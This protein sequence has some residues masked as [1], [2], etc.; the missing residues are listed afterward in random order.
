MIEGEIIYEKETRDPQQDLEE[1]SSKKHSTASRNESLPPLS[2]PSRKRSSV[3]QPVEQLPVPLPLEEMGNEDSKHSIDAVITGP[4]VEELK[5]TDEMLQ[6]AHT[7]RQ[8]LQGGERTTVTRKLL[9]RKKVLQPHEE[10]QRT[11]GRNIAVLKPIPQGTNIKEVVNLGAPP[12]GPRVDESGTFVPHSLLGEVD[13]YAAELQNTVSE[14]TFNRTIT[15]LSAVPPVYR[16]PTSAEK[17]PKLSFHEKHSIPYESNALDRWKT[18]MMDRKRQ[19]EQLAN[20]I[21][22]SPHKLTM[23][24]GDGFR[25]IQ[26]QRTLVDRAIPLLEHGKGYRV[27]SEFFSQGVQLGDTETGIRTAVTMTEQGHPPEL[28]L[29]G[30]PDYIRREKGVSLGLEKNVPSHYTWK[31]SLYLAQR[32]T[33]LKMVSRELDPHYPDFSSLE[34]VGRSTA[35]PREG[36][37]CTALPRVSSLDSLELSSDSES[38]PEQNILELDHMEPLASQTDLSVPM[39]GPA[40]CVNDDVL[41]WEGP[42]RFSAASPKEFFVSFTSEPKEIVRSSLLLINCGTTAIYFSWEKVPRP[43]TLQTQFSEGVQRFYFDTRGGVLLPGQSL[44]F[45]F[46]FKSAM[47]G[48]FTEYWALCTGPVL[49]GG[50]PIHVKLT[51]IAH[52]EDTHDQQ[53]NTIARTLVHQVAMTT[54]NKLINQLINSISSPPRTP[55]PQ[56]QAACLEEDLFA[57]KNPQLYHNYDSIV[58]LRRLYME[59]MDP[60]L[61][62]PMEEPVSSEG[63][64]TGKKDDKGKKDKTAGGDAKKAPPK[65]ELPIEEKPKVD[66]KDIP[67]WD[68]SV[69]SLQ[70]LILGVEDD[71]RRESKLAR[72]NAVVGLLS[73]PPASRLQP[74]PASSVRR[75]LNGL[76]DSI[77]SCSIQIR[78]TLGLPILPFSQSKEQEANDAMLS[79]EPGPSGKETKKKTG[80]K[81]GKKPKGGATDKKGAG[82]GSKDDKTKSSGGKK[83]RQGVTPSPSSKSHSMEAKQ[84]QDNSTTKKGSQDND[85]LEQKYKN[86]FTAA[87]HQLLSQAAVDIEHKLSNCT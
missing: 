61:E 25:G 26:E 37:G 42:P 43:N 3:V 12:P 19:Q 34:V 2:Q 76:F 36:E 77:E 74:T 70:E 71:A 9:V 33:D 11:G 79:P 41:K 22:S 57:E 44:T 5:I 52:T 50:R 58:A 75:I 14:T 47:C 62:E 10:S 83:S 66:P 21:R 49:C 65:E 68:L 85:L 18:T 1:M 23:N 78:N 8:V 73:F 59:V 20:K 29:V 63:G 64:K 72:M 45:E 46:M 40:L 15:Q 30:V 54:A 17:V 48:V 86:H 51:G 55:S 56:P 69:D 53:R 13:D 24:Q 39:L 4:E 67:Q 7:P 87:V 60:S 35:L 82:S 28:E 6:K 84:D 16:P 38:E 80:T 32:K 31:E 27:G 81:E